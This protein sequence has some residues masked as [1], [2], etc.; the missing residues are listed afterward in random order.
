MCAM[1]SGEP[2]VR[3]YRAPD[4][5]EAALLV[6]VLGSDGIPARQ[7]GGAATLL[8]GELGADALLV[9]VWV[10]P[11]RLAE[12]RQSV[13]R[14]YASRAERQPARSSWACPGCGEKNEG[15]FEICWSCQAERAG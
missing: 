3:L 2:M 5:V 4:A 7:V 14:Y 12:A 10:P 6:H 1:P 15:S 13:D 11:D 8:W 9:E